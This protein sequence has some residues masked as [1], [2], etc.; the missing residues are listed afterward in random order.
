METI[1]VVIADD[2]AIIR[3]GL[4]ALLDSQPD[5]QVVGTAANGRECV[6]RVRSLK[7]HIVVMDISMPE[8]N[9]IDATA[10][11][12]EEFPDI[13][14]I[15]LS[16]HSTQ[17]HVFRAL[18]AGAKG[19][20]LKESAGAVLIKAI[21][22]VNTGDRYLCKKIA[23]SL[24]DDYLILRETDAYT[25][26]L[27]SLSPRESEILQLVV[28]GNTSSEIGTKLHLSPKTIETYRSRLMQK[29]EIKD[30]PSL[31]RFAVQNGLID[32]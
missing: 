21:K 30:I 16:M 7:P 15:M 13:Q 18:K 4:K 2:H 22:T 20:I 27:D 11:I 1:H 10:Q 32:T 6:Q 24:V 29:L 31:V 8:L 25:S 14:I 5:I 23:D 17:D 26:P 28:E 9:G 19:Y 12:K 3:D